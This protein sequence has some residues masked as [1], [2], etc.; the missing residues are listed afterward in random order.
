MMT[1]VEEIGHYL[2]VVRFMLTEI[3]MTT[4]GDTEIEL[5]WPDAVRLFSYF[6]E[7]EH[8]TPWA[9]P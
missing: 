1:P 4:K 8:H 6:Y 7:I 2:D 3:E 5:Y 9:K